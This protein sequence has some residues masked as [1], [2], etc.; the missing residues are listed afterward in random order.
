[1]NP[2]DSVRGVLVLDAMPI[3]LVILHYLPATAAALL[4]YLE[5]NNVTVLRNPKVEQVFQAFND[6]GV[7][8]CS[9]P[10]REGGVS[11][12]ANG[13]RDILQGNCAERF[14]GLRLRFNELLLRLPPVLFPIRMVMIVLARGV[15]VSTTAVVVTF[16]HR[17]VKRFIVVIHI[18][19]KTAGLPASRTGVP[20]RGARILLE[21]I[22]V[23]HQ[24]AELK[25]P[26][27]GSLG[28]PGSAGESI[29]PTES[30]CADLTEL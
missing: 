19:R 11:V 30:D 26:G 22:P 20:A 8:E 13:S 18:Q 5:E 7:D 15:M 25:S 1:M 16:P 14:R 28:S 24:S 4:I 17:E 10:G 3:P 2:V 6:K 29:E 23:F 21:M 12:K 9:K 27:S